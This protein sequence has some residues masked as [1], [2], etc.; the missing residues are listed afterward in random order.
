[1]IYFLTV[2]IDKAVF[3]NYGN[4]NLHNMYF[5]T[6]KNPYWLWQIEHQRQWLWMYVAIQVTKLFL[7]LSGLNGNSYPSFL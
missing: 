4:I 6:V 1:M 2:F 7:I 3:I 5:W